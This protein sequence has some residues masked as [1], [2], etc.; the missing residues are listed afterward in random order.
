MCILT[1]HS[2]ESV[3]PMVLV[4]GV[5]FKEIEGRILDRNFQYEPPV[6]GIEELGSF[7]ATILL[8]VNV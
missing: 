1:V 2:S 4:S 6:H 7:Q 5:C 3:S 8:L